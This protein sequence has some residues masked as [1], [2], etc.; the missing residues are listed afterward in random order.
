MPPILDA[1]KDGVTVGELCDLCRGEV[2][3]DRAPT[4]RERRPTPRSDGT[5]RAPSARG[6]TP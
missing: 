2:G 3:D 4:C 6:A 5:C 1:V